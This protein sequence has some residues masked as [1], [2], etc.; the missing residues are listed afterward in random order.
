MRERERREKLLIMTKPLFHYNVN[1]QF[2]EKSEEKRGNEVSS[3]QTK[4]EG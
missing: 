1:K 3:H 2:E 4:A